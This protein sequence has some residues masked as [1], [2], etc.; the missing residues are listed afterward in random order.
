MAEGRSSSR[1]GFRAIIRDFILPLAVAFAIAFVI[2]EAMAKPY[3]IPTGSMIPTIQENDRILAN[4][5]IYRFRD[6]R[7]GDIV[8]FEPT[9]EARNA[10]GDT[11]SDVPFVKRVIAV[12]GDTV[13]VRGHVPY[14]NGR[15]FTVRNAVTS[16]DEDGVRPDFPILPGRKLGEPVTVPSHSLFVMGDNRPGS[17]DSRVWPEWNDVLGSLGGADPE[18]AADIPAAFV[19]L[20][21]VIGQGEIIYWPVTNL[22]FLR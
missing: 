9:K 19:N 13:Q 12:A 22:T 14:V 15:P 5:L 20:D 11:A 4:R 7:R 18:T 8:V 1:A 10:C 2:Q 16:R 17:C 21:A 3:E 6:P